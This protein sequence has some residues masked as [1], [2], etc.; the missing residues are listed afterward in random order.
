MGT[1]ESS[2]KNRP[3]QAV[4]GSGWVEPHS[5]APAH[6]THSYA[7]THRLSSVHTVTRPTRG[8]RWQHP[9]PVHWT[10]LVI[11]SVRGGTGRPYVSESFIN[12]TADRV[13]ASGVR[14]A[15]SAAIQIRI[16]FAWNRRRRCTHL[17]NAILQ[18][19][20][21]SKRAF[22]WGAHIHCLSSVTFHCSLVTLVYRE[23]WVHNRHLR[24]SQGSVHPRVGKIRVSISLTWWDRTEQRRSRGWGSSPEWTCRLVIAY[25]QPTH[26]ALPTMSLLMPS[27]CCPLAAD[28]K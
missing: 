3:L 23:Y 7:H 26:C 22:K 15:H 6:R 1:S 9:V 21:S 5:C 24:N 14:L 10:V 11:R 2:L 17:H 18:V 13:T 19:A 20:T 12:N 25:A 27:T 4:I 8:A 16:V 28:T